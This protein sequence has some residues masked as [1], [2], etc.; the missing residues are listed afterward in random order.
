MEYQEVYLLFGQTDIFLRLVCIACVYFTIL[1][2]SYS[3]FTTS[4]FFFVLQRDHDT[5]SS[6]AIVYLAQSNRVII[7]KYFLISNNRRYYCYITLAI[8]VYIYLKKKVNE[9]QGFIDDVQYNFCWVN[10]WLNFGLVYFKR[11]IF[12]SAFYK[13]KIFN[14]INK[15]IRYYWSQKTV[16]HID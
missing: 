7:E 14:R 15:S 16:I 8:F 4:G 2:F 10:R 1:S 3:R 11:K 6:Y 13:W 5:L 9:T 12:F